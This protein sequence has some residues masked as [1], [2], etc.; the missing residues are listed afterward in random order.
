MIQNK[1][2]SERTEEERELWIKHEEK[3]RKKNDRSRERAVEKKDEV[4]KILSKPEEKRTK[5]EKQYLEV[6][7]EARKRKNEGDRERRKR[8]KEMGYSGRNL[9]MMMAQ[10]QGY[11]P[12]PPYPYMG[13]YPPVGYPPYP[14]GGPP[15]VQM[16]EGAEG[17]KDEAPPPPPP[18]QQA[19]SPS[20]VEATEG[21]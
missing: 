19:M 20:G 17:L 18:L 11:P 4:D 21:V 8:L 5:M 14:M 13:G 16:G 3:R 9:S 6:T 10:Q 7:I 1:P 12:Y 15:A 2:D